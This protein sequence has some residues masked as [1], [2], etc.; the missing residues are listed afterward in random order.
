MSKNHPVVS[1]IIPTY[2]RENLVKQAITSI[3]RQ[4]FEDFEIIVVDDASL[5]NTSEVVNS[6]GDQRIKYFRNQAN[7]GECA[8]R[9]LGIDMAQGE[10]IAFLDSDDKWLPEK[11]EKQLKVF[12]QCSDKV[13]VVYTWL[14]I[15]D[16]SDRVKYR[17]PKSNGNIFEDL[18]FANIIGSP[19]SVM[20]K[21]KCLD[22]EIRF[23]PNLPCCG[24]WDLWLQL[25]RNHDFACIPEVLVEYSNRNDFDRGSRNHGKI[26]NG[27]VY[28]IGK[29]HQNIQNICRSSI[30]PLR[31]HRA[32]YLF[33]IGRRL[34][35][36]A[37][38]KSHPESL[39]LGRNY[40]FFALQVSPSLYYFLHYLFSLTSKDF[41]KF[42]FD[43]ENKFKQKISFLLKSLNRTPHNSL[44][45]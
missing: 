33:N 10:Y 4:T 23:D 31:R 5:D 27:Y 30:T 44:D 45:I 7:S 20:V 12:E 14:R 35:C 24:D 39:M 11:L 2:N 37:G 16:E 21:R 18:L 29:H 13:G 38:P 43:A 8:S 1:V 19:S 40:L 6:I 15:V 22:R 36:H 17:Q 9:N 32:F 41:Y 3:L 42:M 26:T 25:A 28:F 34:I